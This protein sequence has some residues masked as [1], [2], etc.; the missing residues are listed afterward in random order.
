MENARQKLEVEKEERENAQLTQKLLAN[1]AKQQR[2]YEDHI[3]RVIKEY[4]KLQKEWK[5]RRQERAKLDEA[6]ADA[7]RSEAE[8]KHC[9]IQRV[10]QK[11]SKHSW[12]NF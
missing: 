8:M 11:V 1:E 7:Q 2:D 4:E 5:E 12:Q 9:R 6:L 3:R 10:M